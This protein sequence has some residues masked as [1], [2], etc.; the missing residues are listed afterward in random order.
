MPF[1]ETTVESLDRQWLTNVGAFLISSGV[2]H[3]QP[4]SSVILISS[5]QVRCVPELRRVLRDEG[6]VG[7]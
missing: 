5:M 2:P 7:S 4:G 1:E 3:L 6:A